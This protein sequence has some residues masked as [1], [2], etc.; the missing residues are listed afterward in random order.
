MNAPATVYF[1]NDAL[2]RIES[3][4]VLAVITPVPKPLLILAEERVTED[5]ADAA[6][7]APLVV[8]RIETLSGGTPPA[9]AAAI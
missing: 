1:I 4:R 7:F 9:A 2:I 3:P 8:M 6:A 5:I